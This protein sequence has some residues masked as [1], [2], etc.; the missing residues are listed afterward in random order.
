MFLD[1]V[2]AGFD[3]ITYEDPKEIVGAAGVVFAVF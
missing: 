1:E 3:L 2:A